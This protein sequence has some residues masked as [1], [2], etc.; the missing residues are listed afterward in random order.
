MSNFW[1][2]IDNKNDL[3]RFEMGGGEIEPIP[4]KTQALAYI[5]DIKWTSY[6]DD[7]YINAQWKIIKPEEYKGRV[8]FQK[9]KVKEEDQKKKEKAL[10]MLMAIDHNA[11][12]GLAKLGKEPTTE[13]LKAKLTN[14]PMVIM[15]MMWSMDDAQTGDTK[16]GNWI[17]AVSPRTA[18]QHEKVIPVEVEFKQP[19][20]LDFDISEAE[21]AF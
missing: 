19:D 17:S 2:D 16:R 9:I 21:M 18:E 11:K 8:I 20:N 12:G 3:G 7:E 5:E 10:R 13:Q 15:I 6:Q 4:S 14:K 1:L